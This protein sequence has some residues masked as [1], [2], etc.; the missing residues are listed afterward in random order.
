M[1]EPSP[2]INLAA[3]PEPAAVVVPSVAAILS[4]RLNY[5]QQLWTA[6]Q[7]TDPT[8]PNYDVAAL[9]SDPVVML[10]EADAYR[11]TLVLS[12]INDAVLATN[13]AWAQGTNLDALG[14]GLYQTPRAGGELDPAYRARLQLAWENL[15]AG[16]SYGGYQFKALSAAPVDLAQVAVYGYND[17]PGLVP[18]E[19]RIVCLGA[20][21]SGVPNQGVLRAVQAACAPPNRG[22]TRKLNDLVRVVAIEPA[23]YSVV[24]SIAVARGAD[25]A[26]VLAAQLASLATFLASR[27]VIGGL[28]KPGD[29]QTVL[30]FNAPGLVTSATVTAPTSNVGGSPF[31]API[32]SGVGVTWTRA[33]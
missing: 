24:A 8:L 15:T 10:Q 17:A 31:A 6:A 19:V 1:A 4:A 33:S 11:E 13:L 21:A 3:L 12:A 9:E 32:L 20:N 7:A 28:I 18:G 26:T 14:Q 23:A 5:F 22:A 27:R 2:A 25:P 16:G 29:I 30:G